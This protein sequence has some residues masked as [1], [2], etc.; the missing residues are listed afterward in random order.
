MI[1]TSQKNLL[2]ASCL[3]LCAF[4]I[5]GC[6]SEP[7][8]TVNHTSPPPPAVTPPPAPPVAV[9]PA[10]PPLTPVPFD[11]AV[12]NAAKALFKNVVGDSRRVVVIDPLIDGNN[13]QQTYASG[14]IEKRLREVAQQQFPMVD[15]REFSLANVAQSPIVLVGTFTGITLDNKAAVGRPEAYRICLALADLST[16]KIISKGVARAT[17]DGVNVTPLPY[18]ADIPVWTKDPSVDAYIKTCQGTKVGDTIDA[19][20]R[21]RIDTAAL[22]ADATSA[23]NQGDFARSLRLYT[24]AIAAP[25]GDQLRVHS[26]LYMSNWKLGRRTQA[27]QAFGRIVEH[28]L[29]A[30]KI[31]VKFLFRPGG[32]DFWPDQNVSGPYPFWLR[33]ISTRLARSDSCIDVI[34]HTSRSGSE[35]VNDRVSLARAQAIKR[36]ID[37]AAPK[38]VKR[39]SA[40]G[41]GFRE[42][43]IGTGADDLTDL[44]DRRVEFKLVSCTNS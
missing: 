28:G 43:I 32:T 33:Q 34:G 16:N 26:G 4:A 35:E 9:A 18:Y 1:E 36:R 8:V 3:S 42:N 39:T 10:P 44:P 5:V 31:A 7:V 38:L 17:V 13:G 19:L 41:M 37:G 40:K 11:V 27:E 21:D 12:E 6:A 20:Y 22:I 29:A 15:V 25:T 2:I 24:Q 14:Y 23:Y 30:Q